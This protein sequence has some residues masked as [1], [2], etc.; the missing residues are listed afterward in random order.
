MK[1]IKGLLAGAVLVGATRAIASNASYQ[2]WA[3]QNTAIATA[4]PYAIVGVG[5][6]A[7]AHFGLF[8][9]SAPAKG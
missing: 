3:A 5:V 6:G 1:F 7:A 4:V 8:K 9:G 2:A